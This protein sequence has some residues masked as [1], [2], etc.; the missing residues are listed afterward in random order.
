MD[1]IG[2]LRAKIDPLI[3]EL[4]AIGTQEA[5]AALAYLSPAGAELARTRDHD[6]AFFRRLA[7]HMRAEIA[8]LSRT[9]QQLRG[10][11]MELAEPRTVVVR[12]T[13]RTLRGEWKQNPRI[14]G[15][16]ILR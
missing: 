10:E 6:D 4:E 8:R 11:R 7:D 12:R 16:F 5:R 13:G 9:L 1:D 14:P 15:T 3:T 2:R